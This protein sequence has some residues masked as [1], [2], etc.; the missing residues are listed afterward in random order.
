M[1][2]QRCLR[3]RVDPLPRRKGPNWSARKERYLSC[4]ECRACFNTWERSSFLAKFTNS[5]NVTTQPKSLAAPRPHSMPGRTL[6]QVRL[7]DFA[8]SALGRSITSPAIATMIRESF[9]RALRE[10]T[11]RHEPH[12]E[13]KHRMP[14]AIGLIRAGDTI[15]C[16]NLILESA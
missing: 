7:T 3:I 4:H 13:F 15:P 9:A 1:N 2:S 10:V 12:D 5:T 11:V 6:S 14:R 8:R 16:A